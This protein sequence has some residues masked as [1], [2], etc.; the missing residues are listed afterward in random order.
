MFGHLLV[1]GGLT[2][3]CRKPIFSRKCDISLLLETEFVG[4][5]DTSSKTFSELV[6]SSQNNIILDRKTVSGE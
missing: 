5:H 2:K 4:P 3:Q 6:N 1:E